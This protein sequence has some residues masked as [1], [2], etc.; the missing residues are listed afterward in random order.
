M[1]LRL[2]AEGTTP[3]QRSCGVDAA[4]AVLTASGLD[5]QAA[6]VAHLRLAELAQQTEEVYAPPAMVRASVIW[7][8]AT[9]AA[10]VACYGFFS[11][12]S[13]ARLVVDG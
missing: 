8:L 9:Q 5:A 11:A 13:T 12:S 3:E 2:I 6:Q 1:A 10:V 7:T 4:R